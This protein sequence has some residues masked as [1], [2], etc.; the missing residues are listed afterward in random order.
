LLSIAAIYDGM[1]RDAAARLG[2]M[3]RQTLRDWVHRFDGEGPSGLIDRKA[4]G[5]LP[6]LSGEQ[7]AELAALVEA[8]PDLETDGVVRWRCIDLKMLIRRRL[9]VDY[10]ERTI[11]KLLTRLGFSHISQRPRHYGQNP[12]DIAAF[13]NV[14]PAPGPQA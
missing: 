10:H 13:K 7:E 6:R 8:G 12:E 1:S 5:A 9:G 11:G 2:A 3:D 14:W 4:P